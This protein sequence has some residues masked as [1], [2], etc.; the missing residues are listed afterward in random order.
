[1]TYVILMNFSGLGRG[2]LVEQ[3]GT[4]PYRSNSKELPLRLHGQLSDE[5]NKMGLYLFQPLN[6]GL[7]VLTAHF[8]DV[9]WGFGGDLR[10]I[11]QSVRD[12]EIEHAP[13][14]QGTDKGTHIPLSQQMRPTLARRLSSA[15]Y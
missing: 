5:H 11:I 7:V 12:P 6:E 3:C 1:M 10:K 9:W 14:Q 15:P 13:P 2:K 4:G 8:F